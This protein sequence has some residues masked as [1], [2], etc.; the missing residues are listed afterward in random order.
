MHI[1]YVYVCIL[2]IFPTLQQ[3]SKRRFANSIYLLRISRVGT[4]K[5]LL[6]S[7]FDRKKPLRYRLV[8][9]ARLLDWVRFF[10]RALQALDFPR[11]HF[12]SSHLSENWSCEN[13]IPWTLQLTPPQLNNLII[14]VWAVRQSTLRFSWLTL[15]SILLSPRFSPNPPTLISIVSGCLFASPVTFCRLVHPLVPGHRI[16]LS[17]GKPSLWIMYFAGDLILGR[18]RHM[19]VFF[20]SVTWVFIVLTSTD[21]RG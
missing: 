18:Y 7:S 12:P 1:I 13:G 9:V 2:F 3:S 11:D 14:I 4:Q 15:V 21:G 10:Q 6:P 8:A 5:R 19:R 17:L 20:V 16:N